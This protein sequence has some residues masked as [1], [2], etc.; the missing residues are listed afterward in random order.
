MIILKILDSRHLQVVFSGFLCGS[1]HIHHLW[2]ICYYLLHTLNTGQWCVLYCIVHT[3]S[4]HLH[5]SEG[6]A[7]VL[8]K[9]CLLGDCT[10]I[11]ASCI[12]SFSVCVYVCMFVFPIHLICHF[13]RCH[14]LFV[15]ASVFVCVLHFLLCVICIYTLCVF[16]CGCHLRLQLLILTFLAIRRGP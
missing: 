11:C 7:G 9:K 1:K 12:L 13:S 6:L 3:T 14:S 4:L 2:C 16:A 8:G 5:M 15:F 10:C